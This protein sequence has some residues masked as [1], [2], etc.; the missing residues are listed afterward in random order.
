MYNDDYVR[1]SALRREGCLFP[2]ASH[3][4]ELVRP[5]RAF[6]ALSHQYSAFSQQIN[7]STPKHLNARRA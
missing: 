4:A 2:N 1:L 7:A 3:W 6:K 5:F